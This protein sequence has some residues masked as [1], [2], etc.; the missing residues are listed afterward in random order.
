MKKTPISSRILALACTAAF[1]ALGG[2][3]NAQQEGKIAKLSFDKMPSPDIRLP[4]GKNKSF[5]PKDWME[6]EV[7]I[8]IP[9]QN[10]EQKAYGFIDRVVVKWYVAMK[11]KT[12]GKIILMSK[13]ITHINVPVDEAFYSSA[14]LSPNTLKRITGSKSVS[15]GMVE[16]VGV[17]VLVGGVKIAEKSEKKPD[18]WWTSASLS[19]SSNYPLLNK[20]ETPFKM[21]WYDRYAE[22][23]ER[24]Q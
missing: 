15:S 9:A 16:A 1:L 17:E 18:R 2:A 4:G 3:A 8:E 12:T 23:E 24:R 7:E 21:F 19:R 13:D 10:R 11:E 14:Y 5:R 20:S 22:I 6:L